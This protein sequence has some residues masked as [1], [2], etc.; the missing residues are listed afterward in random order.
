MKRIVSDVSPEVKRRAGTSGSYDEHFGKNLLN[1][2]AG[3]RSYGDWMPGGASGEILFGDGGTQGS[4]DT[5]GAKGYRTPFGLD[6][7]GSVLGDR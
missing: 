3:C 4:S 5:R 2:T 7:G 6:R 1:V